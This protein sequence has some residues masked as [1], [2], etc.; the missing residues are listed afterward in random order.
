MDDCRNV[1]DTTCTLPHFVWKPTSNGGIGSE[2]VALVS[3]LL[4]RRGIHIGHGCEESAAD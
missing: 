4:A 1:L 2:H 3:R